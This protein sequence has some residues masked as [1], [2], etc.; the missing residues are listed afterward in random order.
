M[1][2]VVEDFLYMAIG[3]RYGLFFFVDIWGYDR[4]KTG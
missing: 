3:F 1:I 2:W 4:W